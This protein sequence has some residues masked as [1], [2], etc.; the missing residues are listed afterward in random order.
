MA[1]K[2][3]KSLFEWKLDEPDKELY[4]VSILD[5]KTVLSAYGRYAQGSGAKVVSWQAFLQGEMNDLIQSTMGTEI[6]VEVLNKLRE[7]T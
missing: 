7:I 1:Y 2:Q 6:L 5:N 3:P 4:L